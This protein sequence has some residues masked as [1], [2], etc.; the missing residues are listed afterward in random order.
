MGVWKPIQ[1]SVDRLLVIEAL[2]DGIPSTIYIQPANGWL[3]LRPSPFPKETKLPTAGE[4][5]SLLVVSVLEGYGHP[6]EEA[7]IRP[8][9]IS[10][11][12]L[13]FNTSS[14]LSQVGN[15]KRLFAC[16]RPGRVSRGS[17]FG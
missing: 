2:L 15:I 7:E 1:K 14:Y 13:S 3:D 5:H 17:A 8:T 4:P 12:G 9:Q 16:A 6:N 10:A 11:V